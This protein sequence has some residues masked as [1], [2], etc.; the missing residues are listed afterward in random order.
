MN[1]FKFLP[2]LLLI[3]FIPLA[4]IP[5]FGAQHPLDCDL[6]ADGIITPIE[7][8]IQT[9]LDEATAII[10]IDKI[11][12]SPQ[13]Y[14]FKGAKQNLD[15]TI[16][17]QSGARHAPNGVF[18]VQHEIDLWNELN[19]ATPCQS[20]YEQQFL[21]DANQDGVIT[22]QELA[23][24][25]IIYDVWVYPVDHT[26]KKMRLFENGIAQR[27]PL[28]QI[29]NVHE[30]FLDRVS[31]VNGQFDTPD[32]LWYWNSFIDAVNVS[33]SSQYGGIPYCEPLVAVTIIEKE[34]KIT[35]DRD[36]SYK[37]ATYTVVVDG[38]IRLGEFANPPGDKI[39]EDG[40]T[41][42]GFVIPIGADNHYFTG[43]LLLITADNTIITYIDGVEI[44]NNSPPPPSNDDIIKGKLAEI[45]I[46]ID[47]ILI[48]L[49]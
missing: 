33:Y 48:L 40:T 41:A 47:E 45:Q 44:P 6:N 31:I 14:P 43:N 37:R 46:L 10:E 15:G 27:V 4:S 19:P 42:T 1:K 13:L 26:E 25:F 28:A 29:G 23:N 3:L 36:A 49:G 30:A 35:G 9:N 39:S 7:L 8:S 38:Q 17:Y 21:C 18:D 22:P 11:E 20:I 24:W 16:T 32:E 2:L 5:I 12:K 34:L